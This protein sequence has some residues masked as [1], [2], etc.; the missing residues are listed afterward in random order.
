MSKRIVVW[1]TGVVG[2]MVIA[3]PRR[4][5]GVASQPFRFEFTARG[6]LRCQHVPDHSLRI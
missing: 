1:G 5:F 2:K 6:G 4:S 3:V